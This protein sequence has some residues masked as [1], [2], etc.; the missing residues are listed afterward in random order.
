M[1]RALQIA[2]RRFPK[3]WRYSLGEQ[4]QIALL[5][6]IDKTCQG[7]YARQPLKEPYILEVAGAVQTAQLFIRLAFEEKLINEQ[8]FFAWS[9]QA[10]ELHKMAIGWLKSVRVR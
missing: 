10:Q 2:I 5:R 7:L 4:L 8:Q 9:N 6:I 1:F 3:P